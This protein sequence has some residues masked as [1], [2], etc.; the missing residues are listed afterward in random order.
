LNPARVGGQYPN[1]PEYNSVD[2]RVRRW[3]TGEIAG[4]YSASGKLTFAQWQEKPGPYH[5]QTYPPGDPHAMWFACPTPPISPEQ[6]MAGP[7]DSSAYTNLIHS[8]CNSY[9][10]PYDDA[11][12]LISCPAAANLNYEVTFMCPS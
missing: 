10:Y 12:G 2:L 9:A 6:C 7:A 1:F 11:I 5:F 3:D 4:C 8:Y